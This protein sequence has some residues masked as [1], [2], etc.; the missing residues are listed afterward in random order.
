MDDLLT[1]LKREAEGYGWTIKMSTKLDGVSCA[2]RDNDGHCVAEGI[3]HTSNVA[4]QGLATILR[5]DFNWPE[6]ELVALHE[7]ET[8][9]GR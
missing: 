3:G 6:P 1:R 2:A 7:T 4:V 8:T 5:D 9:D